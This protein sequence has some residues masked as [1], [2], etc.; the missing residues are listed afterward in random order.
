MVLDSLLMVMAVIL[1]HSLPCS[2][3]GGWKMTWRIVDD[4]PLMTLVSAGDDHLV[5]TSIQ[6]VLP[7]LVLTSG[8]VV[9]QRPIGEALSHPC[10]S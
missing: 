4:A 6:T 10:P 8:G 1:P 5:S 9:A 7:S 2:R 3:R